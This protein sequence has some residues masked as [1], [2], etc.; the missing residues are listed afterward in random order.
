MKFETVWIH[1]LREV[2]GWL[3]FRNFD[4][5]A[6]WRHMPSL[7]WMLL[8]QGTGKERGEGEIDKWEASRELEMKL[9][10]ELGL[11]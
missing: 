3:S 4:T 10:I 11:S 8:K 5:M 1:F 7:L 2:F 9:L 6:T